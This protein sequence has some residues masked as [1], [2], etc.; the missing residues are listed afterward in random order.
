VLVAIVLLT[1][2]IGLSDSYSL[3]S[4]PVR[5]TNNVNNPLALDFQSISVSVKHTA[6][7]SPSSSLDRTCSLMTVYCFS[8]V[9]AFINAC[10]QDSPL[11][12][13]FN[14]LEVW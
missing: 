7:Y 3:H 1:S 8:K 2:S 12:V 6:A 9:T 4:S 11:L 10:I 13:N 5:A 14:V